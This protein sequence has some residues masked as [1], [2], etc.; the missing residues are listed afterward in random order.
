[1]NLPNKITT[2]RMILVVFV[3]TFLLLPSE[4]FMTIPY[5]DVSLNFFIAWILFIIASLSDMLDGK[6]ARKYN[7]VTP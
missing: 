4:W 7:M 3:A 5:I 1:M 6:I 2:L